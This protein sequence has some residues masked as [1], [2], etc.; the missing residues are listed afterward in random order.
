MMH[1]VFSVHHFY[2]KDR[3]ILFLKLLKLRKPKAFR[4]ITFM[5]LFVPSVYPFVYLQSKA[6]NIYVDQFLIIVRQASNYFNL[7]E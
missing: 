7:L 5:A 4:F 3:K 6:F 2:V 1:R